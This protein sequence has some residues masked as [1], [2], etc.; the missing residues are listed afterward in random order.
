MSKLV[1]AGTMSNPISA[2]LQPDKSKPPARRQSSCR[3]GRLPRGANRGCRLRN[4]KD[5]GDHVTEDS[6]QVATHT[7][8]TRPT[9]KRKR[10][11]ARKGMRSTP[12]TA[13]SVSIF[14]EPQGP[15]VLSPT[16]PADKARTRADS[17]AAV[18]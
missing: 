4:N 15:D 11:P 16:R 13:A 12:S 5:R 3:S 10:R 1:A 9:G 2:E 18:H 17:G 7:A 8:L 6:P 14:L